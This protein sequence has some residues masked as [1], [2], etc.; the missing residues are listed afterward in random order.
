M[1]RKKKKKKLEIQLN[2]CDIQ[3]VH[4]LCHRVSFFYDDFLGPVSQH[5]LKCCP[6]RTLLI[7]IFNIL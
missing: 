6:K 5:G 1:K 4:K 7:H 3:H 2:N